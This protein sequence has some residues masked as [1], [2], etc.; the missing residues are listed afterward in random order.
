VY[1]GWSVVF[2]LAYAWRRC[3]RFEARG[4]WFFI[5]VCFA[6]LALGPVLHVWGREY[7]VVKLPYFLLD[8]VFPPIQ[9]S[10]VPVRMI[11]VSTL[12]ASMLCA[13]G[14]AEAFRRGRRDQVFAALMLVV[15]AVE[16][17]PRP[18]V[19][20]ALPVP[21]FVRVLKAQPGNGA[22]LDMV[23]N[24]F[25]PMYH[26]TIHEKP[27]AFGLLART[28]HSVAVK[29]EELKR[30][31]ASGEYSKLRDEYNIRYVVVPGGTQG[32][33]SEKTIFEDLRV[34]VYDLER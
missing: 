20:T 12:A 1:L 33:G 13:A 7:S 23:S 21:E 25:D 19:N 11:I 17:W 3:R 34:K 6:V 27:M 5:V 30:V 10:G 29:N 2:M 22:V 4:L 31:F 18:R 32:G 14:F 24:P 16:Y 28:P 9:A 15:L 26:Q 8:R